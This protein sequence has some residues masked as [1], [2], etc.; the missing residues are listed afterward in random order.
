MRTANI[1]FRVD[2]EVKA[3]AEQIYSRYGLTLSDAVNIFLHKSVLEAG[4]P[5]E[6][7][8]PNRETLDAVAEARAIAAGQIKTK[9]YSSVKE[10]MDELNAEA[11]AEEQKECW[12]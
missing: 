6:L 11:D 2:P 7:R 1:N 8:E 9:S 10:M 4:L 5:F 3:Q 12:N